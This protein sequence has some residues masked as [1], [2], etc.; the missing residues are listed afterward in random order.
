MDDAW[1]VGLQPDSSPATVLTEA[2]M[3]IAGVASMS[4]QSLSQQSIPGASPLR[5]RG[6]AWTLQPTKA[7]FMAG[8][9]LFGLLYV[10]ARFSP[11]GGELLRRYLSHPIEL[12]ELALFCLGLGAFIGRMWGLR[13]ERAALTR[14]PLPAQAPG[15]TDPATAPELLRSLKSQPMAWRESFWGRRL[16]AAMDFVA[17]RQSAQELDDQ[18]RQLGDSDAMTL[19]GSYS[20][21]RFITWAIPIL[22]FLG[23][24]LGITDA[25]AGV[26]PEVLEESLSSVTD[27][28]ALA[29]DSTA[30]ALALTMVLMFAASNL[31]RSES[32]LLSEV[33]SQAE[34]ALAHRFTRH[35]SDPAGKLAEGIDAVVRRLTESA[36]KQNDQQATQW[37][38][39][40]ERSG[41]AL[42]GMGQNLADGLG[43]GLEKAL[44]AHLEAFTRRVE[45][46]EQQSAIHREEWRQS[47]SGM[48]SQLAATSAAQ[49][50][51]LAG[52][53]N[54]LGERLAQPMEALDHL[55]REAHTLRSLQQQSRE[56]LETVAGSE[57]LQETLHTLTAAVH[58]LA[59]QAARGRSAQPRLGTAGEG[60]TSQ[61]A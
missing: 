19:E 60:G 52:I 39:A 14:L 20:I 23:T 41:Q 55:V 50:A 42:M 38:Q 6:S 40:V 47:I 29:F 45:S 34:D 8:V 17:R 25:I 24:V 22:G 27:G 35:G 43:R 59:G 49:S 10:G 12:V 4:G 13:L 54:R 37:G 5:P 3:K 46:L 18:L 61:A 51:S 32:G 11:V 58:L 28:L 21:S 36:Q 44:G 16:L 53:E 33:D 15:S 7:A 57:A 48:A 2:W 26:T 56:A 1:K 31:E 30:L 9:P